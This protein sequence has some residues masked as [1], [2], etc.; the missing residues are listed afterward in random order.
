MICVEMENYQNN[1]KDEKIKKYLEKYNYY[2]IKRIGL[3]G[4]FEL[5]T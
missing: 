3:N 5:K 1:L 2:L 4:F